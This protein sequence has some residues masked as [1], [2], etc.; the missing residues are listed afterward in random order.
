[1]T[2]STLLLLCS[3]LLSFSLHAQ[4]R[5]AVGHSWWLDGQQL[6]YISAHPDDDVLV[7]PLL[8]R[9]CVEGSSHCTMLVL[10]RGEAGTCALPEGCSPDLGA[11]REREMQAAAAL[12]KANLRQLTLPDVQDN[13]PAAWGAAAGTRDEIVG[14]IAAII[15]FVRPRVVLTFDPAHGSTCHPAHREVG[16]LVLDALSRLAS[17][18]PTLIQ[19]ETGVAQTAASYR[20]F[21]LYS[22]AWEFFAEPWWDYAVRDA[23]IHA[24]Q[25][26]NAQI[27]A[28]EAV[29]GSERRIWLRTLPATGG[30]YTL[31][32]P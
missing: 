4:K 16:R 12:F 25:F 5:R 13:V 15:H 18:V 11:V 2:R 23:K 27:S 10:T 24:S 28:L 8:G 6:L 32:C 29:P 20:F 7:A 1:M 22:T 17:D 3:L 14:Q 26:T 30:S 19:V 21:S 9:L 31:T